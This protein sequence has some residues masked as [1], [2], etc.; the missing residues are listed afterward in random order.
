MLF[1]PSSLEY[2]NISCSLLNVLRVEEY[3]CA[4]R[5]PRQPLGHA[6]VG[7]GASSAPHLGPVALGNSFHLTAA[8]L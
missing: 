3:W 6:T 4:E 8:L 1:F 2:F 5:Q 7:I